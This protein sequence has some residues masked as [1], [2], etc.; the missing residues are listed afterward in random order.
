MLVEL[1]VTNFALIDTLNLTFGAGLNILTGET[2][3]GKSIIIDALGL[4]LGGRAG[5]DLV[6]TGASKATVE[7]IFDLT[8]APAEVR[9]RLAEEGLNSE[10]DSDTLFVTRELARSGGKS[11][12]RINGRLMPV[13]VLKEIAEGLVDVHGQHEHQSLLAADR[14]IDILDNWGGKDA[15][16]LRSQFVSVFA[17]TNSLKRERERLRTDARERAR[18]LDLYRY[19]QEEIS[20]ASLQ[21]SEE[22]ELAADR[23]RLA[24]SEKLSAA[25]IEAYATLS[26]AERGGGALDGLNSALSAVEHAAVLDE[27]LDALAETLRSAVS[28]ADDAARELRVYQETVEFNPERLEEIEARLDLIR[29]LK[30]KY[31]ETVEEIIAYGA[32]LMVKLDALENSEAR[33]EELTAAISKSEDKQ[34][35]IA[36][37]LTKA[38]RK[39]S[40]HFAAGIAHELSD[41]GMAVTKFEVAIEPSAMTSK[42]ADHV[43]FLLSPNPGEPLR[44]LAKIASGGEM[45]RIM[46]AMKSVL[47]R[48]GAVPTMI[49]DEIDVGVGGRTAQTIGDKLESLA[50]EAQ[51]MCITHLPQIASRPGTHFFIEK[52]VHDGRTTV[53]VAPLDTEGRI[54]EIARMLGGSRRS[55]AV[56]QH[57]REMLSLT[58]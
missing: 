9:Q 57:A 37:R 17:E 18:M 52:Q 26:G 11:Q 20:G 1:H 10:E 21:S 23:T 15:L 40:Q 14:H 33:E 35:A 42:G 48:T 12:C 51:I 27:N 3:A 41:L 13:T 34:T 29:T 49:F 16:A 19:Q 46:L 31:G 54:D 55:E 22:E 39:A 53:S 5:A 56:V 32:E 47:A 50:K 7:A 30:R 4:A 36:T 43:E 8:N 24:N 25:A 6:R 28:Y 38:R 45:S 58:S 44:P 2:G